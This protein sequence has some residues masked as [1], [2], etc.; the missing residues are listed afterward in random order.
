MNKNLFIWIPKTGGTSFYDSLSRTEPSFVK[1]LSLK[2]IKNGTH[3]HIDVTTIYT[4]KELQNFNIF[5]ICRN[6]YTRFVSLYRYSQETNIF[7]KNKTIY[8]FVDAISQGIPPVGR[9]NRIGLSQCNPQV[10]WIKMRNIKI[11]RFESL[12]DIFDD[13]SIPMIW[14]NRSVFQDH[15]KLITHDIKKFIDA[16]Y[17]VDFKKFDYKKEL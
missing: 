3:G 10:N 15:R 12:N 1:A 5:T 13:F 6:P 11:Y 2:K 8:D 17:D 9:Y 7:C 16:F 14:K 4:Q